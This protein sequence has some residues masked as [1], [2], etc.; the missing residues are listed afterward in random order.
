[1]RPYTGNYENP[2][3][4]EEYAYARSHA[5]EKL[6]REHRREERIRHENRH[7][8]FNK[9]R[10]TRNEWDWDDEDFDSYV[11]DSYDEFY[12]EPRDIY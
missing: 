5:L 9:G 6:L 8:D 10:T 12:E 7:R 1:M 3:E 4:F 11:D 2:E